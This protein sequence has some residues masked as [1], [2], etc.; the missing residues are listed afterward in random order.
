MANGLI[1]LTALTKS[2]AGLLI[3]SGGR[4]QPMMKY[5]ENLVNEKKCVIKFGYLKIITLYL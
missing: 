3:R 5:L 4:P 2:L 1:L